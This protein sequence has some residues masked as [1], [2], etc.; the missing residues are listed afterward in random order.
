MLGSFHLICRMFPNTVSH[1][2]PTCFNLSLCF[3]AVCCWSEFCSYVYCLVLWLLAGPVRTAPKDFGS[4]EETADSHTGWRAHSV[5]K[6]TTAGWHWR[7][8]WGGAGC[9]PVLVFSAYVL[10]SFKLFFTYSVKFF[11]P[12][13]LL[14]VLRCE[15]LADLIWQNRQQ[16]RRCEHLTQQLPLPGPM[17]E[18]LNKLNADITD[19]ISALVT[20]WKH[21]LTYLIPGCLFFFFFFLLCHQDLLFYFLCI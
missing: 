19:I 11:K 2:S 1:V 18:L 13:V 4:A 3:V 6:E 5:E 16:I 12:L 8:T 14:F 9:P 7:S 21:H 10:L 20:R 15:K 17:E